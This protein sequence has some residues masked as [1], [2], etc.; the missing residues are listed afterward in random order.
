VTNTVVLARLPEFLYSIASDGIYVNMYSPSRIA[1]S[2]GG[3]KVTLNTSTQFPED[4]NVSL[5]LSAGNPI[6]LKIR[7]RIPSW[8]SGNVA[9]L[10]N[11]KDDDAGRPGTYV[12]LDRTWSTG[13]TISFDVPV[14]FRLTKYTGFDRDPDHERY[15]LEYGPLLMSLVGGT[16]LNL[17]P[18]SLIDSLSRAPGSPLHFNIA[19]YPSFKY[20]PYVHIQDETFTSFPTLS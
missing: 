16:H 2:H 19:G 8:T 9:V 12:T 11:G 13:D 6:P 18:G 3:S 7:L 5:K 15:G 10:V 20:V 14:G 17:A 1:W 4:T